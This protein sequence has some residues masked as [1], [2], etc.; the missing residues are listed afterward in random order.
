[1][2]IRS[3]AKLLNIVSVSFGFTLLCCFQSTGAVGQSADSLSLNGAQDIFNRKVLDLTH[4]LKPG[5]PEFEADANSFTYKKVESIDKDGYGNG[6]FS[7]IEHYGTHV[8]APSHFFD[9]KTSVDQIA[10]QDLVLPCVVIDVRDEVKNNPDYQLTLE[11]V[12][13]F[14]KAAD[15][16][17]RCAVLLL[18]GWDARW[19]TPADYRNADAKGVMHF[20]G[21]SSDACEYLVKQRHVA[22]LGIDTLSIDAGSNS[23]FS[24]HKTALGAGLYMMENLKDLALLPSRGALLFCGPLRIE[25]GTGSPA[26]IFAL[27]P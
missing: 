21:F 15:I 11:R 3:A 5:L 25:N 17:A 9:G 20:P 7:T 14:E 16:P 13:N 12:K 27:T 10:A 8:D 18:T 23:Q 1:M 26:R 4:V 2:K 24:C 22:S 6:F 19:R